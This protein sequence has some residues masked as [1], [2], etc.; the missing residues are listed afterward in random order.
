MA[1]LPDTDPKVPA[2]PRAHAAPDRQTRTGRPRSKGLERRDD[3]HCL[4]GISRIDHL[5]SRADAVPFWTWIGHV[6]INTLGFIASACSAPPGHRARDLALCRIE[7]RESSR[8]AESKG[9]DRLSE[10]LDRM[11]GPAVEPGARLLV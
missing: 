4:L 1:L 11:I 9:S 5:I 6:N 3:R 10:R 7:Q 2:R 8:P